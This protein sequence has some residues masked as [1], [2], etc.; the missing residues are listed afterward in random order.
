MTQEVI[1]FPVI[2]LYGIVVLYNK[3]GFSY[4]DRQLK[5]IYDYLDTWLG[6]ETR[7]ERFL[8]GNVLIQ[9]TL[10]KIQ[11]GILK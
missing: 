4:L 10:S 2:C 8:L 3:N 7:N 6:L 9:P 1:A 11:N 5:K